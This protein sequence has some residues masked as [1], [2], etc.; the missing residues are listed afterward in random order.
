MRY[1][2]LH[3]HTCGALIFAMGDAGMKDLAFLV[4]RGR[5]AQLRKLLIAGNYDVSD[6]GIDALLSRDE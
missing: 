2:E 1:L 3:I 6:R 5:L 4:H